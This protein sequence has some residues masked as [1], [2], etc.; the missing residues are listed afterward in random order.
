MSNKII[1]LWGSPGS[2]KSTLSVKI[3]A[4]LAVSKKNVMILCCDDETPAIPV[5][6]GDVGRT[7]SLG[8]LLAKTNPTVDSVLQ[9]SVLYG[10]S[11]Y[12]SLLGYALG[13]N[14]L[15]YPEYSLQN[16]KLLFSLCRRVPDIDFILIDC[17]HHTT[18][19]LL[20]AYALESADAVIR[21]GQPDIKSMVFLESQ[22]QALSDP[23]FHVHQHIGVL[24]KAK[25]GVTQLYQ[26]EFDHL[27]YLLP[28][29]SALEEQ[30]AQRKLL[31]PLSGKD[32][33]RFNSSLI[34]LVQEVFLDD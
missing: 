12:I 10:K 23:K 28:R 5:L 31:D 4:A 32:G 17:S 11:G 1:A 7:R 6:A 33:K 3:A 26:G 19:N 34:S 8:D 14:V 18:G 30:F 21:I 24:N 16:V 29:C 20:T 15:T 13:E 25:A 9:H 22:V 27:D 2:G